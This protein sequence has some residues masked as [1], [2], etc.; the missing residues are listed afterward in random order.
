[1]IYKSAAK[2]RNKAKKLIGF[3]LLLIIG[4]WLALFFCFGGCRARLR[5]IAFG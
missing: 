4:F 5:L 3:W 2:L 1:L